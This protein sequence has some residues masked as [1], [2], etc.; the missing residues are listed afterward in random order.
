MK[1]KCDQKE[2]SFVRF[3]H[4]GHRFLLQKLMLLRKFD[5]T[6]TVSHLPTSLLYSLKSEPYAAAATDLKALIGSK[7]AS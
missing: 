3:E 5:L 7:T 2:P 1:I 6:F 4:N